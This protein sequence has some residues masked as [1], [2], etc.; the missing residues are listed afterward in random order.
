MTQP[1]LRTRRLV[2]VP[3][4]DEHLEHEVELDADPEV[5]RFLSATG[6]RSREEVERLHV[7][8]V[9]Q[10]RRRPGL[11]FWVGLRE[12]EPVGWWALGPPDRDEQAERQAE[13][14][15]RLL[16]RHWGEGLASEGV[17]ALLRYAFSDLGLVRVLGEARADHVASRRVMT[18]AGMAHVATWE[19]DAEHAVTRERWHEMSGP[20]LL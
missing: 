20:R 4:G 16:R 13:V 7:D 5:M 14:A 8:R 12:G 11:G 2:L 18:A 19:E 9:E 3:L 1:V 6:G 17:R 10:A 15:Y